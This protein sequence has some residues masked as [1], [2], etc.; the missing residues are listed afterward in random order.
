V[1]TTTETSFEYGAD[2]NAR[3]VWNVIPNDGSVRGWSKNGPRTFTTDIAYPVQIDLILPRDGAVVPGPDV[4]LVW[5]GRDLDYERVLYTVWLDHGGETA[6]LV[7]NWDDPAGPV[8]VVPDLTPGETYTWWVE[9]DN[10]FSPRGESERWTFTVASG[11][12]P[13]VLLEDEVVGTEGATLHW[14]PEVGGPVPERYDVHL[15]DHAGGPRL[16]VR[17]TTATSMVVHDLVED[18]TYHWYV[19]PYDAEGRAG[20]SVPSFRTFSYDDN[21]P[22]VASIDSPHLVVEP[23][24][25]VLEW[26]GQDPDGDDIT[27]DV[28]I[29]PVNGTTLAEANTPATR[30]SLVLDADRMYFWRVVP[31][32]EF[33]VGEAARG[34][35]LVGPAG[36]STPAT[37]ELLGPSDGATVPPP[38]VNLTWDATDPLGRTL[39][40]TIYLDTE[41]GDPFWTTPL[42]VN[43]TTPWFVVELE[44][45]IQVSWA[46]EVRPI[47]GP[48]S[49][50]GTASFT[51]AVGKVEAPV[52]VLE[53]DGNPP[54]TSVEVRALARVV[55]NGSL[56][57]S[58]TAGDLEYLFDYG[59]GTASGWVETPRV[60][61]TYLTEGTYN[62]GLSVRLVD[63]PESDVAHV[64]VIVLPGDKASDEE[65]PGMAGIL[66]ALAM[67]LASLLAFW[68]WRT[69]MGGGDRG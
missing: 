43:A 9:G 52:A 62:A 54:G 16:L 48:V 39:L 66:G 3:L 65:V 59:D 5:Y 20:L 47:E 49:L 18:A 40:Y 46:V 10:P 36:T 27:Y 55:L 53:V 42:V 15:V 28:F 12:T 64:V 51:V 38:V 50:L 6:R 45:G 56:S 22:P 41:G 35:V 69:P 25:H 13:V 23:G 57:T 14:S 19:V 30:L 31:R 68:R 24:T 63:G 29:D 1:G 37:G 21:S 32:D 4:K 11:G 61:H 33:S 34:V 2:D 67:M 58:S 7:K 60:E 17:G 44:E 26:S 8:L